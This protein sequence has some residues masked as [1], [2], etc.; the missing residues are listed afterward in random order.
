MKNVTVSLSDEVAKFAKVYAAHQYKSLSRLVS[1]LI[2]E[3][4]DRESAYT[5]AAKEFQDQKPYVEILGALP[6]REE[7]YDRHK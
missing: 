6:S 4:M 7:R 5:R 3:L 2:Q 1:E